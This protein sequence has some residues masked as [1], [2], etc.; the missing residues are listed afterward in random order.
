M[1]TC[2]YRASSSNKTIYPH[3][4]LPE[5]HWYVCVSFLQSHF[6]H[7]LLASSWCFLSKLSNLSRVLHILPPCWQPSKWQDFTKRHKMHFYFPYRTN[8]SM[9]KIKRKGH[10]FSS[11]SVKLVWWNKDH[12]V[13]ERVS[14]FQAVSPNQKV[15]LLLT[16]LHLMRASSRVIK[17]HLLAHPGGWVPHANSCQPWCRTSPLG[18]QL[19]VC[20]CRNS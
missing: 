7:L 9:D 1:Q 14:W 16:S 15:I 10:A 20:H 4:H 18:Q 17:N 12:D 2:L 3:W 13:S 19:E 8:T 5:G 11:R 6:E